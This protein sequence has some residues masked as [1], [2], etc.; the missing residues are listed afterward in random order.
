MGKV[1]EQWLSE[2]EA[3]PVLHHQY[4]L[5]EMFYSHEPVLPEPLEEIIYEHRNHRSDFNSS[6]KT[7]AIVPSNLFV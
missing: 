5:N 6:S 7:L 2:L 4:W 1:K 3:N